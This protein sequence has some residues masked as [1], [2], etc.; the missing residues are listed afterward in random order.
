[1]LYV[2]CSVFPGENEE[3]VEAFVA[4]A[5]GARR[6]ALPDGAPGQSLPGPE[7]DGF[8]HALLARQA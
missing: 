1:L 8:F 3:V 5:P 7:R 4:R 2:T 6:L